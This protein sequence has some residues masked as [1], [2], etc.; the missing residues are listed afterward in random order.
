[1]SMIA[2]MGA[3]D[4]EIENFI[5][6]FDI[7]KEVEWCGFTFYESSFN[8]HELVIIKSGVGKVMASMVTQRL[9]DQYDPDM[10][11]FTGVAGALNSKLEIGDVVLSKDCIQ[12][13]LDAQ[14]LGFARGTVSATIH[15]EFV[16]DASLLKI[17]E[18]AKITGRKIYSGRILTGDQFMTREGLE[19]HSYLIDELKGD[20]VEMEGSAVGQVCFLNE[21][22]FLIIRTISDKANGSAAVDF[23][24][25]TPMAAKNSYLIVR[26]MLENLH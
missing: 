15:R 26:H 5:K 13:D 17:A 23:E 6:I 9:I 1:M 4:A 8:S 16:A 7:K 10:I 14:A 24:K 2:I 20:A 18:T 11:L 25:F 22:P 19:L 12:H 3:M 21:T